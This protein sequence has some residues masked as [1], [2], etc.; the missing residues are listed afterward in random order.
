MTH[1]AEGDPVRSGP[2]TVAAPIG[3]TA[4]D[5]PPGHLATG[6]EA[7]RP[8]SDGLVR[9][10]VYAYASSFTTPVALM[11]GRVVHR[12]PYVIWDRGAPAG[13]Y[14][15]AMLLA[16]LPHVGWEP[17]V[18]ELASELDRG[19]GEAMLFSPWPTPDLADRG[20]RLSG[21]PPL[22]V[23]PTG[24]P[25]LPTPPWLEVRE[26]D[27]ARSLADWEQVAIEGYPL[28]E[29]R[30][31]R[32]GTFVDERILADPHLHAW[33]A[34]VEGHPIAIGTSYVVH[35]LHVPTLG[36]TLPAQRGRG[37][38]HVLMRRRLATFGSLPA[39]ALFSDHSRPLAE[40][41]GFLPLAR[42]TVWLRARGGA[43]SQA[44]RGTATTSRTVPE[45]PYS[46][47]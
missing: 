13:L 29:L 42:W 14:N 15:G 9:R 34:Y 28:E 27:G 35:G 4:G 16:P 38:W 36:V 25:D 37:A 32:R 12:E 31:A 17:V 30:P 24:E 5:D 47:P 10:F 26:V 23:R 2:Q 40:G 1:P 46:P 39:M 19:A 18:D 21:H 33:V 20:W 8:L 11:G 22:L 7:H 41:L 45:R 43:V 44:R 6:W 3:P